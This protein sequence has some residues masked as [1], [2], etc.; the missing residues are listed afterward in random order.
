LANL[1]RL[2]R[3]DHAVLFCHA[4]NPFV[5]FD[6]H[7]TALFWNAQIVGNGVAS[8][9]AQ[10]TYDGLAAWGLKASCLAHLAPRISF[11]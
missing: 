7:A 4:A 10:E 3:L 8:S 5:A 6:A 9:A 11:P 1:P 2:E